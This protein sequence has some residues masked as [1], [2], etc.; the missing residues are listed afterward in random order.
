M[1]AVAAELATGRSFDTMSLRE[2]AKLAGIAPTSFYR[3]FHH[4]EDLGLAL[5]EEHGISL[6]ALMEHVRGQVTDGR[7]LIRSSIEAVYDFIL[8]NQGLS[9]M[10]VQESLTPAVSLPGSALAASVKYIDPSY[11]IRSAPAIE[12]R[13]MNTL[14]RNRASPLIP[15]LKSSSRFSSK[16][17]FWA[18]VRTL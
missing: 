9:R 14:A 17:C 16:R 4:L 5:I 10:I 15:K 3:H 2:V 13:C 1:D 18:S 12:P 6:F 7:S 11:I 8:A